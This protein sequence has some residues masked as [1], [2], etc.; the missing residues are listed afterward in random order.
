MSYTETPAR[1]SS[2][3]ATPPISGRQRQT[4]CDT[5]TMSKPAKKQV[6]THEWRSSGLLGGWY[7]P[8]T[9]FRAAGLANFGTCGSERGQDAAEVY[10]RLLTSEITSFHKIFAT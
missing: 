3:V 10:E 4:V 6:E 8:C 5:A 9:D 1:S 2:E 7:D